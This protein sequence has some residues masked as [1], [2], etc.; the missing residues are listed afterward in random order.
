MDSPI[1]Y[2]KLIGGPPDHETILIGLKNGG[3]FQLFVNNPFPI[4]IAKQTSMITCVDMN[5]NR[6]KIAI[7]DETSTLYVYNIQ[8]KELLYQVMSIN[9]IV[10]QFV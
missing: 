2:L 3:V 10:I 4:A 6:T 1:R 8:T 7:I 9:R 5:V